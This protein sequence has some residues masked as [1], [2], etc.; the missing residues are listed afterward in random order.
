MKDIKFRV[1]NLEEK[2]M[3]GPFNLLEFSGD[4]DGEFGA[5]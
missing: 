3:K 1:W 4:Q 2:K 5:G